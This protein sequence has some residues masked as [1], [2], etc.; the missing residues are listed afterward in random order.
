MHANAIKLFES[1]QRIQVKV[2]THRVELGVG[3]PSGPPWSVPIGTE[4]LIHD[5]TIQ[6]H[7]G[8]L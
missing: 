1:E 2:L 4:I 8:I 3:H 5:P 6:G 7:L